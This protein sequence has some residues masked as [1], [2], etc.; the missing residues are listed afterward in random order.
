[1]ARVQVR[2]GQVLT[3]IFI[4]MHAPFV[5]VQISETKDYLTTSKVQS[6]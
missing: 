6:K 4:G 2:A 5:P 1:M 3:H